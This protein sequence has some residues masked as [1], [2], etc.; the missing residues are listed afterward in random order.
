MVFTKAM[1][2]FSKNEYREIVDSFINK[3]GVHR[4]YL[5]NTENENN[6]FHGAFLWVIAVL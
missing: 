1:M 6:N 5:N 3:S 4:V 2:F